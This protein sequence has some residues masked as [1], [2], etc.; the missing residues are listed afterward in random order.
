M[1][2]CIKGRGGGGNSKN[3]R[4]VPQVKKNKQEGL[5]GQQQ[6]ICQIVE[7][8]DGKGEGEERP[9]VRAFKRAA[10]PLGIDQRA[11]GLS[12]RTKREYRHFDYRKKKIE[13]FK[14]SLEKPG[15][16][17]EEAETYID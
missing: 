2:L 5:E 1:C 12:V 3:G 4:S 15:P 11:L 7:G 10:S 6:G 14:I 9:I 17:P 8:L 13:L 16:Y